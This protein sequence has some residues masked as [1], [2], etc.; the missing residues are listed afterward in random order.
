M[1]NNLL[2]NKRDR[3]KETKE[4][5]VTLEKLGIND[6]KFLSDTLQDRTKIKIPLIDEKIPDLKNVQSEKSLPGKEK[7]T[8]SSIKIPNQVIQVNN[9]TIASLQDNRS[10][11]CEIKPVPAQA[12]EIPLLAKYVD[13]NFKQQVII[14]SC[15]QWFSFDGIHDIETKALPEFFCGVY[16]SK[17]AEVYKEYRN[18]II[19]LYR[20]NTNSY[21]SSSGNKF[22]YNFYRTFV[23]IFSKFKF[24][25][26]NN[27]DLF[28]LKLI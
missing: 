12:E 20:E 6:Y 5:I 19:N 14:P 10:Q 13:K 21:L 27:Y 7:S 26:T 23:S 1:N 17:T 4:I 9:Q 16:P 8:T 3:T 22:I 24:H 28:I 18:Y 2:S 15:A 25:Q 11:I